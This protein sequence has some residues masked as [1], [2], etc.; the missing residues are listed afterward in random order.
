[1]NAQ[2]RMVAQRKYSDT[3]C[4]EKFSTERNGS[5]DGDGQDLYANTQRGTFNITSA[6]MTNV[7]ETTQN[8]RNACTDSLIARH[9]SQE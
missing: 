7:W 1:M 9:R 3:T 2:P 8:S 6:S 5:Y 4:L